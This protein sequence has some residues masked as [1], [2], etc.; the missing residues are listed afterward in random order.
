MSNGR[1]EFILQLPLNNT[2]SEHTFG[3]QLQNTKCLQ[4]LRRIIRK[5]RILDVWQRGDH[6]ETSSYS[7]FLL[8][9]A[10]FDLAGWSHKQLS[11]RRAQSAARQT[12]QELR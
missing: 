8:S 7:Q 10:C 2:H 11:L 4:I 3:K 1:V 5:L 9:V 6:V 12:L